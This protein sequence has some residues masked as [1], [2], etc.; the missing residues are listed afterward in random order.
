MYTYAVAKIRVCHW[1]RNCKSVIHETQNRYDFTKYEKK[2]NNYVDQKSNAAIASLLLIILLQ[3]SFCM[4]YTSLNW[5]LDTLSPLMHIARF[6]RLWSSPS[7]STFFPISEFS[8]FI[9]RFLYQIFLSLT[10]P[11]WLLDFTIELLSKNPITK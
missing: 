3:N 7:V 10:F 6:D 1:F 8:Y 11:I 5:I 9:I 2:S 4:H